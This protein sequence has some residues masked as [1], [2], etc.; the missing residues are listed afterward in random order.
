MPTIALVTAVPALAL[1]E[2]MPPLLAACAAAGIEACVVAWDDPTVSWQRF[3]AALLRSTWDYTDRLNAFLAWCERVG[4]QTRLC[5]A[6]DLVRW[7]T[8]KRYLVELAQAGIPVVPTHLV[9]SRRD[10]DALPAL[11]D[12]VV[13]PSVGA[14]SRG[15]RRFGAAQRDAARDHA[16]DLLARGRAVLVQPYMA[17]VDAQGETALVFIDGV[18][19]HAIAKAALL[20]QPGGEDT[21]ALFAPER[22]TA[23]RPAAAELDMACRIVRDL[24]FATPLYARI[25]LLPSVEG[26]LLL[27]LEVTEPSLFLEHG[28][29]AAIRL[30]EALLNRVAH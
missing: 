18:F 2:D 20:P 11:E 3:D 30:V 19:S 10:F 17:Q 7:N 28:G 13:K 24:P 29:S 26:P 1:D 21:Q 25:D 16:L 15:A 12:F 14:G 6:A 8:D 5:N 22:I 4:A 9:Q 23:R 27:E